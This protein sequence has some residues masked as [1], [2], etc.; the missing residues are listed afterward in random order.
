MKVIEVSVTVMVPDHVT[1][2]EARENIGY[3]VSETIDD[4]TALLDVSLLSSR[5]I[6][7]SD[8]EKLTQ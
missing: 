6:D 5:T 7:D 2:D 3:A 8:A 1:D 4:H